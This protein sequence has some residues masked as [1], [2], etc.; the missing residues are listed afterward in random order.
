MG[1]AVVVAV[2]VVVIEGG[3]TGLAGLV[4]TGMRV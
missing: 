1:N 3:V 4:S 2:V